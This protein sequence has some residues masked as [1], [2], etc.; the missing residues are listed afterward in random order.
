MNKQKQLVQTIMKFEKQK[1]KSISDYLDLFVVVN[2]VLM[3]ADG[4]GW[5]GVTESVDIALHGES[6]NV[7]QERI[8]KT[9]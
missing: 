3:P 5:C 8:E 7:E 1:D 9:M 6:A 4:L 2:R